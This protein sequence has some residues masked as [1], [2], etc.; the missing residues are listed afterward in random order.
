MAYAI[1]GRRRIREG[2]GEEVKGEIKAG[3]LRC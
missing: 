1:D 2:E 3:E